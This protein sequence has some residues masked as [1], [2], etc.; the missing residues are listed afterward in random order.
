MNKGKLNTLLRKA[1]SEDW[2]KW[3]R[4][5]ADE[6]AVLDGCTFDLARAEKVRTFFEKFLRHSKSPFAGQPF[7]LLPWQWNDLIGPLFGWIRPDGTRRF[8]T[9]FCEIAKK[10]GK[11]TLGSGIALYMLM[12]DGEQGAEV[13]SAAAD[14]EQASIV[15]R[16]AAN[17]AEASPAL[18]KHLVVTRSTKNI[19]MPTTHSYYRALSAEHGTKEGLNIHGLLFDE[20][21]TQKTRDLWDTLTYGGAARKQPLKFAMTTAGWDRETICY[22]QYQYAKAVLSGENPD[23]SFFAYIAEAD[24]RADWTTET[25]WAT[26]NPSLGVTVHIEELAEACREAKASPRK[27]NAFRRYRLNQWTEQA[28]RWLPME[29]W[30][31]GGTDDDPWQW[32]Q[33]RLTE[34]AGKSCTGGLDLGSTSDLTALALLFGDDAE[35]YDLLPWFWMPEDGTKRKDTTYRDMYRQWIRDEWVIATEGDVADYERIRLDINAIVDQFGLYDLAVDRLFQ[36]AQ[37]CTDLQKDGLKVIAFGQGFYSMAAPSKRF[38]ELVLANK[39]R[40]GNNPVMNW[41]ASNVSVKTDPAGNLKPCKPEKN[42]PLKIDGIVAAIMAL[43][44]AME[45]GGPGISVYEPEYA[46]RPR[47]GGRRSIYEPAQ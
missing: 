42:S 6:R 26:A 19:T 20:L 46:A 9:A 44:R 47:R 41:M 13:Y 33:D 7:I 11:S 29:S 28:E 14:R 39:I 37:L 2:S 32:R 27:E 34:L 22:E 3:I 24:E 36:G 16:E 12:G 8:R 17:M 35:G 5:T 30:N 31:A 18:M 43:G 25:T 45:G 15:F 10:N 40:H 1:K 21:H 4:A 23:T 38:E